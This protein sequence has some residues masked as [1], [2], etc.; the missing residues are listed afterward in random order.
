MLREEGR[1]SVVSFSRPLVSGRCVV[2]DGDKMRHNLS[3]RPSDPAANRNRPQVRLP[4]RTDTSCASSGLRISGDAGSESKRHTCFVAHRAVSDRLLHPLRA[5]RE[6]EPHGDAGNAT[7]RLRLRDWGSVD[8]P[9]QI[10]VEAITLW[11]FAPVGSAT[12][13]SPR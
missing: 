4:R 10:P 13:R 3:L 2:K 8:E 7:A 1:S 9:T 11:A 6:E 5:D 12:P